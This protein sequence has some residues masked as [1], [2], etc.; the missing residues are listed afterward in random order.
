MHCSRTEEGTEEFV[1]L[2]SLIVEGRL[3][4]EGTDRGYKEGPHCPKAAHLNTH[5]CDPNEF[6][7]SKIST[8]ANKQNLIFV[9]L[10]PIKIVLSRL[11]P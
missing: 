4:A 1:E 9:K 6:L 3:Q 2:G 7:V 10:L 8:L 5:Q 11:P